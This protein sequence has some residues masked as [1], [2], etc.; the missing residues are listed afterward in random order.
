MIRNAVQLK[1]LIRN[2]SKKEAA[3]AQM[4]MRNYMMESKMQKLWVNYQKKFS[5]AAELSWSIVMY[6]VRKLYGI[7]GLK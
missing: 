3:N 6:S 2:L 4:L 5:Y 1:D 7:T